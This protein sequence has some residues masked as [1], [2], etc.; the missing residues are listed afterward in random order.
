MRRSPGVALTFTSRGL[1]LANEG[2]KLPVLTPVV[3]SKLCTPSIEGLWD[4]LFVG[5]VI[6]TGTMQTFA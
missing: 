2:T 5:W 6:V 4:P 3:A 1:G